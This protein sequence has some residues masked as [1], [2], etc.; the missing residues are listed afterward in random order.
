M[1]AT[2]AACTVGQVSAQKAR[3]TRLISRTTATDRLKPDPT[4]VGGNSSRPNKF[5]IVMAQYEL[6]INL[7]RYI[8]GA[9][10]ACT[11]CGLP[12][13]LL[14][15]QDRPGVTDHNTVKF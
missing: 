12:A 9:Y 2:S 11:L 5:G 3:V 6:A 14:S 13:F 7:C 8:S 1:Y 10:S 15:Q 4:T